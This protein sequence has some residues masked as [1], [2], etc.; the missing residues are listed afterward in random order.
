MKV[1]KQMFLV[2][3]KS[4]SVPFCVEDHLSW[5]VTGAGQKKCLL[6]VKLAMR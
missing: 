3:E 2:N 1:L 6:S 5:L 4:V